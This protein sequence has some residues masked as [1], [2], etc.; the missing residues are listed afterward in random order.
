[1][2]PNQD[3][4]Q[5][6]QNINPE[7]TPLNPPEPQ[8]INPTVQQPNN[9]APQQ[10]ID[11]QA[12]PVAPMQQPVGPQVAPQAPMQQPPTMQNGQMTPQQNTF[13]N[14]AEEKKN[15]I[16]KLLIIGVIVFAVITIAITALLVYS[17]LFAKPS[18]TSYTSNDL[19]YTISYP[20]DWEVDESSDEYFK[21][22]FFNEKFDIDD[23]SE[24][25]KHTAALYINKS[26]NTKDYQKV[27]ESDFFKRINE[28]TNRA[29]EEGPSKDN[30]DYEYPTSV[31][32]SSLEGAKYPTA[33]VK[34]TF[35]NFDGVGEK[36][37]SIGAVIWVDETVQYT[38][39]L[40]YHDSD[41]NYLKVWDDILASFVI[42]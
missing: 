7:Q 31:D 14:P 12:N 41:S 16:K 39:D 22:T 27:N 23:R 25:G 28:N 1:M 6:P 4:T 24:A 30:P 38:I 17:A 21:A 13:M 20:K 34:T 40:S 15:P 5:T 18:L 37:N 3:P 42:N 32:I 26:E 36:G 35:N 11:P 33:I 19:G 2:N 8:T 29:V 10:Q 9:I